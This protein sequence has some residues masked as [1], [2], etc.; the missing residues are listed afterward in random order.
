MGDKIYMLKWMTLEKPI[1]MNL[2]GNLAYY[3]IKRITKQ[4]SKFDN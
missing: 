3:N 4:T 1:I 2:D